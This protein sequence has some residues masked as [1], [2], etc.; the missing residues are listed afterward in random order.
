MHFNKVQKIKVHHLEDE[1]ITKRFF[2]MERLED[3]Y[4]RVDGQTSK[5]HRHDFYTIIWLVKGKGYHVI[6]FNKFKFAQHQLYFI[7]PGQ[8]HQISH[9]DRPKGWSFSFSNDFLVKNNISS[10][11]LNNIN[12]FRQYGESPPLEVNNVV[13]NELGQLIEQMIPFYNGNEEHR[14]EALGALLLLFLIHCNQACTLPHSIGSTASCL[15]V[16]FKTKVEDQ[17]RD[18]H[19]V[20]EYADQMSITAKHLN[21]VV[22][23]TIGQT[24]KDYIV[25]RIIIEA[26]RLLTHTH[27][28]AKQIA[29]ELGFKEAL[30]FSTFFKKATGET[31]I[32][33]R[34]NQKVSI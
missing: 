1:D 11:F 33:F 29:L 2:R 10:S 6:D 25:D 5:P 24:A 13:K 26:K 3:H 28:T 20:N 31:P 34:N 8:I 23:E 16:D 17:F 19:K 30:H 9:Y 14:L 32:Q 12:M 27:M 18:L 7:S 15:L 22:K 4:D 21:E